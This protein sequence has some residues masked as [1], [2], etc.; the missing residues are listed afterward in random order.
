M[1]A[2][3]LIAGL[4]FSGMIS[5]QQTTTDSTATKNIEAVTITKKVFKKESDRFVYDVANSPIAKGNTT[6]EILKQTPLL[7]STDDKTLRIAGKNNAL[8][9]INGRKTNM[10]AESLAQ[11]LKNTPAE[12]I[13]KIEVITTPGSEYQVESS[14]GIINNILKKK[15]TDGTNGNLRMS[16]SHNK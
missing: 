11:F 2:Q 13:Q 3:I 14:D 16:N 5:A 8:I 10:D 7:S 12:N 9:F 4:F 1:K 15:M 6:F